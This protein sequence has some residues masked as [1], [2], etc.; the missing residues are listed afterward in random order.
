[1]APCDSSQ[2]VLFSCR[3]HIRNNVVIKQLSMSVASSDQSYMPELVVVVGGRTPRNLRELKEVRI[4]GYASLFCVCVCV[5][6]CLF[7]VP[8]CISSIVPQCNYVQLFVFLMRISV[9][10][11]FV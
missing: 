3:L 1:M 6:V 8:S 2:A 9:K 7:S 4:P 5:C 11:Q 10:I